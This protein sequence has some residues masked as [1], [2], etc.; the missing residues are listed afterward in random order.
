MKTDS[1]IQTDV[2]EE[3]KWQSLLNASEIGVAVKDGIVTLSGIVDVYQKKVAAELAAKKVLGVKA[4]VEDIDVK[5]PE[6][7]RSKDLEIA[8]VILEALK[9]N[10]AVREDKIRIKVELG[11]VTLD[12]EVDWEFQRGAA[13]LTVANLIGVKHIINNIKVKEN[14]SPEDLKERIQ[15][16]FKRNHY[17]IN[18]T[19]L[20]CLDWIHTQCFSLF[21]HDRFSFVVCSL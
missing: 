11:V 14:V 9:W 5:T 3:L 2:M 1:E 16:A 7:S 6:S 13:Y 19:V 4:I 12:G 21:Y 18:V 8:K 10:S 17:L 15:N 20:S